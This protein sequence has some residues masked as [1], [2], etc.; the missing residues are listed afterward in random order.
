[1]TGLQVAGTLALAVFI[2]GDIWLIRTR[3]RRG[4]RD[5]V[6]AVIGTVGFAAVIAWM[7]FGSH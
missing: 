3:W 6:P 5:V 2:P 7:V 1:M 4:D